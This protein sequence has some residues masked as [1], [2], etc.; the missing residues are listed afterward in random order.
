MSRHCFSI[1]VLAIFLVILA[2]PGVGIAKDGPSG[3]Q[4]LAADTLQGF[5]YQAARIRAEMAPNRRYAELSESDLQAVE[6]ALNEI[7]YMLERAESL[8]A[9][10]PA[11]KTK[12]A[13]L[14]ERVNAILTENAKE[15][16]VC[17]RVKLTGS[18]RYEQVCMT[19]HE[20][21]RRQ[22]QARDKFNRR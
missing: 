20:R 9:M 6:R 16:L 19:A 21:K 13:S 17:E 8:A 5:Q 7:H 2:A 1:A 12:L 14:Q 4:A 15:E 3:N 18:N 10:N 22:E 11:Q